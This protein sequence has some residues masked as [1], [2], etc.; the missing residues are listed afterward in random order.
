M[1]KKRLIIRDQD[2]L[3][4]RVGFSLDFDYTKVTTSSTIDNTVPEQWST[5]LEEY[6]KARRFMERFA[7][8]KT[9]LISAPGDV[10]RISKRKALTASGD[11]AETTQLVGH[12]E[13]MSFDQV[14]LTPAERGNA[15]A[16]TMQADAKSIF[17]LRKEAKEVLGDWASNKIDKDLHTAAQGVTQRL[18]GGTAADM[19][20]LGANDKLTPALVSKA[21][22]YL[23]TRNVPAF[24][25]KTGDAQPGTA[26]D[27]FYIMVVRPEQLYDLT[28][29]TDYKTAASQ[30]ASINN[31]ISDVF[32][33]FK[34]YWD[35]VLIY[36]TTNCYFANPGGYSV[37]VAKAYMFGPRFLC[38]AVG[39]YKTGPSLMWAEEL[40]DYGRTLGIATRWFDKCA[41]LN[42]A[43]GVGVFTAA[44]SL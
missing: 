22:Y 38:R 17:D 43:N 34:G 16:F 3:E 10:I 27:G 33:G 4:Q 31:N 18:Y 5:E 21:K 14:T 23:R 20:H 39:I 29:H 26:A 40:F 2:G 35:G 8:V 11:L 24:N 42:S 13:Q 37:S 7:V 44:S 9:D 32:T 12:E 30:L 19:V 28:T 15:V 25:A 6:L 41:L 1:G 36:D